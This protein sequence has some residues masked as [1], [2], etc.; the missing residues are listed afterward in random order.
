[1]QHFK[2][3]PQICCCPLNFT[4]VETFLIFSAKVDYT[5]FLCHIVKIRNPLGIG[6]TLIGLKAVPEVIL[7]GCCWE[8]VNIWMDDHPC[9][10]FQITWKESIFR[11]DSLHVVFDPLDLSVFLVNPT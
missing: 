5:L 7:E 2:Q 11:N 4:S 1:M 6:C 9:N 8:G 3:L 10:K